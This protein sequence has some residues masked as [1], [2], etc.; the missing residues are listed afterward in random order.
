MKKL[1]KFKNRNDHLT[2][3]DL[4]KVP[5]DANLNPVL[6]AASNYNKIAES[7]DPK[8]IKQNA[9]VDKES[10]DEFIKL[11][12]KGGV[13]MDIGCGLGHDTAYFQSCGFKTYGIDIS[14]NAI[15]LAKQVHPECNYSVEDI[16]DP[17]LYWKYQPD[18]VYECLSLM[19]LPK[20]TIEGVFKGI[21]DNLA[22]G[23]VFKL[24]V[25][26]DPGENNT[27]WYSVPHSQPLMWK[28]EEAYL[29]DLLYLSY[30]KHDEI[31][32]M[33]LKPGFEIVSIK[34]EKKDNVVSKAIT[35]LCRKKIVSKKPNIF[36]NIISFFK[37]KF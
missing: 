18:G 6:R 30:F 17:K 32:S 10:L 9:K 33:L 1:K 14:E 29:V 13:I 27:G 11:M 22:E 8:K 35:I 16:S 12:P 4:S 28:G 2:K 5:E 34:Q 23:G 15:N 37:N 26:E 19:N 36:Q 3:V 21:Y 24:T 7:G 31:V 20:S 25:E